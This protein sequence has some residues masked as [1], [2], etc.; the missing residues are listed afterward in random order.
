VDDHAVFR[1]R[2]DGKLKMQYGMRANGGEISLSEFVRTAE[3]ARQ[4]PAQIDALS[5]RS[6]VPAP[7]SSGKGKRGKKVGTADEAG[8]PF[9]DGPPCLVHMI[10]EGGVKPGGQN[11]TLFHMGVYYKKKFPDTWREELEKANANFLVP[12]GSQEGLDSV[13]RSLSKTDYEYKCKSEPMRSHC[14][15]VLCRKK[16]HGVTG[17]SGALVPII[18]SIALMK[19]EPPVWFVEV[20]GTKVECGTEDLQQWNRFQRILMERLHNPFGVIPQ[21]AWLQAVQQ[22]MTS[23]IDIIPISEDIQ[24]GGSFIELLEA[25]LTNRL[26]GESEEDLLAGRPWEDQDKSRHYFQISKLMRFLEREG[27]KTVKT[28]QVVSMLTKLNGGKEVPF[29]TREIKGK[30]LRLHYVASTVVQA[31]PRLSTPQVKG[32]PI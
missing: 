9:G 20:E 1:R 17:G 4:T 25:Y 29:E 11:D 24:E 22:A 18:T 8:V 19:S 32:K 16:T 12:A 10:R 27:M 14:D 13:V 26:R 30:T 23:K 3:K 28:P 2:F 6:L 31:T 5:V 15:A 21:P 7:A